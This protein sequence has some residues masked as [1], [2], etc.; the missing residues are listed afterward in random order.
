MFWGS[1][2]VQDSFGRPKK[3]P[4]RHLK[5]S[6]TSKNRGPKMDL[7]FTNLLTTFGA[8]LGSILGSKSAQKG[9][10]KWDQFWNPLAPANRTPGVAKTENKREGGR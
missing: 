5:S 1:K 2:A 3:A 7:I 9:D 10:Q 6:K 8:I 4:K